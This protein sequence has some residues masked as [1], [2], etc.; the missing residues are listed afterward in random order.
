MSLAAR[1]Y[2][3]AVVLLGTVCLALGLSRW[4][5][6]D[7]LRFACYLMLA[8]PASCLKV[9]LPGITG[10]MSVLFLFLLAG[11]VELG[12]GQT[13][14][15]GI[16]SVIVQS[17]W[18]ARVRPRAVQV[19]FSI[20][21]ISIAITAT[22]LAYHWSISSALGLKSAF[23]LMLAGSVFFLTNTFPI[24]AVIALT[25]NKSLAG[26]WKHC[27]C[28]SFPYYLVGASIVGVFT[29]ANRILDWQAWLLI[30]PI[31][32]VI[33]RSYGL[34]LDQ[35][36]AERSRAD[37]ER[38]HAKEAALLHQQAADALA[39][40]T[41]ANRRLD[42][43]ITTKRLTS[44]SNTPSKAQSV[45]RRSSPI[46]SNTPAPERRRSGA[47]ASTWPIR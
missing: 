7:L 2:I 34:Y 6:G 13:L 12:M 20:A 26:V 14:I 1:I 25:E 32:Y 16:T 33:Y 19:I 23:R 4:T 38:R 28:W 44:S 35:L 22:Y 5:E 21:N 40:A 11:T 42:E 41:E 15:I 24:A 10:T 39:S 27:Y 46:C 31:V 18:R 17:F 29:F 47:S 45:C 3:S 43:V 9:R 36:D 8:V 30:L 37:E